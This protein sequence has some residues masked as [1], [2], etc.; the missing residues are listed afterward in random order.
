[1]GGMGNVM[2]DP[3]FATVLGLLQES[4]PQENPTLGA[5]EEDTVSFAPRWR[6]SL[7]NVFKDLF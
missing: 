7:K 6:A 4:G 2:Q 5:E 1:V 3:K